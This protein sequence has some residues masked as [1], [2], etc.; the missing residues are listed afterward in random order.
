MAGR[1]IYHV[2]LRIEGDRTSDS[3]CIVKSKRVRD[4]DIP[5]R[6]KDSFAT[7][8]AKSCQPDPDFLKGVLQDE[9]LDKLIDDKD[10]EKAEAVKGLLKGLF[11]R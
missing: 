9:V 7:A 2:S 11:N 3:G 5:L 8:G 10:G 1:T 4:K 6:C